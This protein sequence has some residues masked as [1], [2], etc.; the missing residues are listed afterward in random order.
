[1]NKFDSARRDLTSDLEELIFLFNDLYIKLKKFRSELV[2]TRKDIAK[3]NFQLLSKNL[4]SYLKNISR[5]KSDLLKLKHSNSNTEKL[6][7]EKYKYR[8][9]SI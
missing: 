7:S 3:L 6:R 2:K 8:E 5:Y 4:Q 9:W 1:M